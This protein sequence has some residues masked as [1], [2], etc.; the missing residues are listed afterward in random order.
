MKCLIVCGGELPAEAVFKRHMSDSSLVIAADSGAELFDSMDVY[1]HVL[2]GDFDSADLAVVKRF[3]DGG[4]KV[5]TLPIEKNETD[6]E[7]AVNYAIENGA[8]KIVILG[9]TGF[10]L[11]H[12]L[13]NISMLVRAARAGIDCRI[14]DSYNDITAVRGDYELKGRAGQTISIIPLGGN[15]IVNADNL[16]YPLCDL[17]LCIGSSRGISN[18][19]IKSPVR[20]SVSG[21][22]ALVA[23]ILSKP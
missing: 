15:I 20:L 17:K 18:E 5:I 16:K 13:A 4:V 2:I 12:T 11:D 22:F 21:G 6:T 19:I 14:I 10:R 7:A 1:P 8:S 9:A 23:K 3:L